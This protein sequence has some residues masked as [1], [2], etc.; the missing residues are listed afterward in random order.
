MT[1]RA[2]E[3]TVFTPPPLV[4]GLVALACL[5]LLAHLPWWTVAA[6]LL[7]T[8]W[9]YARDRYVAR[10]PRFFLWLLVAAVTLLVYAHFHTLFGEHPG[11]SFLIMLLGL[12]CLESDS[13]RDAVVLVLLSYVALLGDLL[14]QPSMAMGAFALLFLIAS[15]VA[16]SAIAQPHGL[17]M[18]QRFRQSTVI[19][20]QAIPLAALAYVVFPRI[21]GGLWHSAPRPVGQTGLTPDLRPG[22]LSA[23]LSSRAVAMRVIFHGP[24]PARDRRY[25]RAYVLTVTNGR[26]W[27]PGR[28][29][30]IG[31][32]QGGPLSSYTVLLNPTGNRVLPALDWPLKVPNG[33][34]LGPGGVVRARHAVR[35]LLRYRVTSGARRYGPLTRGG[36]RRDLA[37]PA[38]LD[39]R[40][41]QLVARWRKTGSAPRA[42]AND[43][44]TYFV[45][46]HFVYTLNP[47]TM[48]RDPIPRFLFHVR[49]GYCEDY[50]AAFATLMR[51]AG[52]PARVV[53]GFYGGEFNPD[54]GDIIVRDYDAHAWD[55]I[56]VRGRWLRVDPT[57]VVAPGALQE[58]LP[59][60]RRFLEHGAS[61]QVSRSWWDQV[62]HRLGLWRDAAT[63]EWDNWV[64]DYSSRRQAELLRR[65]GLRDAGP[66]A[67]GLVT[68]ILA[69]AA[70]SLVKTLGGRVRVARDPARHTYER[71]CRRL[72]RV[73]LARAGG[74]GPR[75]FSIRVRAAR[76]DLDTE[77]AAIT[78]CY[79]ACRYGGRS[80]ALAELRVRVARFRPRSQ[81][82]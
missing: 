72:E 43:A 69:L 53:V 9:R 8:G 29:R 55:E 38:T 70:V 39:P 64:V 77:I 51:A 73:G 36:R 74:E 17:G 49:A 35:H 19:M 5:P 24:R 34:T 60:F 33:D 66:L 44:L 78:R 57:A 68:L 37:L 63:T 14:F 12:K 47:P 81:S 59:A 6:A 18:R 25:F 61:F 30:T 20:L 13:P 22:S 54:G 80:E 82:R 10:P 46:H 56:W 15:F 23:L 52:V 27:R 58:R 2:A 76:P 42:L 79:V 67:L 11:L 62:H 65:L 28:L 16:L 3:A 75:D 71:Y 26:V 4:A 1:T 7:F 50:A 48:G 31:H 32:T 45:R 40:I 21:A 41:R